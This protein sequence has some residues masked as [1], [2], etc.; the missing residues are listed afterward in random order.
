MLGW[1]IEGNPEVVVD[2]L[3]CKNTHVHTLK[4]N[5]ANLHGHSK[6][7]KT[8]YCFC[9]YVL[10]NVYANSLLVVCLCLCLLINIHIYFCISY[11][12]LL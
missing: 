3:N 12:L 7:L 9:A 10:V 6:Q 5:E 4:Q 2:F 11:I 1:Q 8:D